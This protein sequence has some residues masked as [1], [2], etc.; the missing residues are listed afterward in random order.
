MLIPL[1]ESDLSETTT[2][3]S[4]I[5]KNDNGPIHKV[6][7]YREKTSLLNYLID[8]DLLYNNFIDYI[9]IK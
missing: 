6:H 8:N 5:N 3:D 4:F 2:T 9:K 1:K 7:S